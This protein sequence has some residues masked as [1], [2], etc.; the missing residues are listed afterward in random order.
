[1]PCT[2]CE[3]GKWKWG[4][5]GECQYDSLESCQE[6]NTI[7][8]KS[9]LN[10]TG[11]DNAKLLIDNEKVDKTSEWSFSP[12]DGNDLLGEDGEDWDNY[13][14]WFLLIDEDANKETKSYYKFPFGKDG[15]VYRSGLIAIRQ[16][17]SQFGYEDVFEAAGKLLDLIDKDD[18]N[19]LE[20]MYK[21]SF[22][23]VFDELREKLQKQ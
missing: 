13:A 18:N 8:D 16:R 5:E 1:M 12:E 4:D 2:Q 10:Q 11:Y 3:N 23:K 22:T 9:K 19:R 21:E 15:K 6:A 14:K 7:Y 17:S 20:A